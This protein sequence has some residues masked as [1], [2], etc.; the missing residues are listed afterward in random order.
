MLTDTVEL[1]M[2]RQQITEPQTE[3]I[4]ATAATTTRQASSAKSMPCKKY[5]SI[6]T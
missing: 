6:N 1:Q 4:P 5:A 2:A 3:T